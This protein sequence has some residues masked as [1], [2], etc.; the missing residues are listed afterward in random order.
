MFFLYLHVKELFNNSLEAL[1]RLHIENEIILK[2][3]EH[4]LIWS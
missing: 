2:S 4:M 1:S 3:Y